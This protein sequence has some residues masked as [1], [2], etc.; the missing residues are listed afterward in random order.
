MT[1]P[2]DT[3]DDE[4][5]T[6]VIPARN[7]ARSIA[8]C[9]TSVLSQDEQRLQI[10]VV[11]GDSDDDTVRIVRDHM[12]RD[13]RVELVHNPRRTIPHALNLGVAHARGAWLVRVDAHSTVPPDYVRRLVAHLR[14][15]SWGGVGGRKDAVGTTPA[16][17]AIAA[18]LA[19]PFG[20]G[21]SHYHHATSPMV[22]E[23]IPFGVYPT[24]LVRELGGWDE[25]FTVNEDFEFDHRVRATGR[26]LLLDPHIRI[27]WT[28]RQSIPD[29]FRQYQRYGR[30]KADVMIAHPRATRVRHLVPPAFALALVAVA[31]LRRRS[32]SAAV[33]GPYAAA[34]AIAT[35]RASSDVP[36]ES[37]RYLP[38]AFAA[39]HIAWGVG[40]WEGFL[41][42][43]THALYA[44]RGQD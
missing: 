38:F 5:V 42:R 12:E 32:V 17:R 19:S 41:R 24:S 34:T 36:R 39:M 33:L 14:S 9:L 43:A 10:I 28:C 30:G 44:R 20:V 6:V 25:S 2:D 18:A 29:L 13:R 27:A 15:G 11:D 8:R 35:M 21:D 23:H 37:R 26:K 4:L 7:E 1:A 31:V 3:L 40:V 16:G 22:V